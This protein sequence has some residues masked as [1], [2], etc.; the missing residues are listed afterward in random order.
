MSIKITVNKRFYLSRLAK[1]NEQGTML[2]MTLLILS[3]IL[4]VTLGAASLVVA[5]IN[6]SRTQERSTKAYFAAEAG[7]ERVLWL[8]R[9]DG[10]FN[11]E[12]C[13]DSGQCVNFDT[14]T[15]DACDA[16]FYLLANDTAYNVNYASTTDEIIFTSTGRYGGTR[17]SVQV[18]Y[19][20]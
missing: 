8:V 17:R 11:F 14:K 20:Q 16:A 19:V 18:G 3:G 10:G 4:T 7:A 9:K 2:L 5:G 13:A 15:C 12:E 1:G 6:M